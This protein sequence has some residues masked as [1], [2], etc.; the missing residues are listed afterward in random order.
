VFTGTVS[1]RLT[2]RILVWNGDYYYGLAES[3]D[4]F[5]VIDR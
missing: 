5:T 4:Q 2:T 1:C 3:V